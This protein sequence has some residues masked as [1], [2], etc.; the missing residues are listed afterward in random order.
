MGALV[1]QYPETNDPIAIGTGFNVSGNGAEYDGMWTKVVTVTCY[2]NAGV[3]GAPPACSSSA[4]PSSDGLWAQA[5]CHTAEI[6]ITTVIFWR[7][8]WGI[9][10]TQKP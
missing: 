8:K 6:R 10:K 3:S 4:I 7:H 2:Q 1:I 5:K 9:P